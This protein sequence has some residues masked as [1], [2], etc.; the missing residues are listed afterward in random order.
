MPLE[1]KDAKALRK[2][3]MHA[4]P[5]SSTLAVL[6]LESED[7]ATFFLVDRKILLA[8]ADALR[9]HGEQLAPLQ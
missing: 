7:G 8:L 1:L 5:G 2:Y 4:V 3:R 9:A 6:H